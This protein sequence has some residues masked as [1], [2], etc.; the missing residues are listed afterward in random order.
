MQESIFVSI[1]E[2]QHSTAPTTT[3]AEL[4]SYLQQQ[5]ILITT[6]RDPDGDAMGSALGLKHLLGDR[7]TV[8]LP[9]PVPSNLSWMPGASSTLVYEPSMM[10][11]DVTAVVITDLNAVSRLGDLGRSILAMN[12]PMVVID[13]HTHPEAFATMAWIDPTYGSTSEMIARIAIE[14]GTLT[15]DAAT[16]LYTG[17][18]TDSG[19]FRFPRTTAE[20]FR[21]CAQLI[22]H[23]AQPVAIA[24]SVLDT[25]SFQRTRL[26]GASQQAMTLHN[27][28]R[29][30]CMLVTQEMLN[31]YGVGHQEL[32]GFVQSTLNIQ[33][34]MVGILLV[35]LPT[36]IKVS[37]RSKG[38]VSINTVAQSFGG[39]GHVHAAGA[40]VVG[41]PLAEV[42][43]EVVQRVAAQLPPV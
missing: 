11:P 1:M 17:I 22:D 41:S 12:K 38:S 16:C 23:G 10:M 37:L 14:H 40:R 35:E 20:T 39:G 19:G 7:A 2:V 29:V 6:H 28:N 36:E 27:N 30:A 5:S 33:G 34:T 24:A 43:R 9:S 42:Q 18:M 15:E 21:V 13:H 8:V 31:T 32:D 25:N 4:W 26:F 3:T